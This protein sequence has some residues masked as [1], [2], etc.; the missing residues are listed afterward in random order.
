[1][2]RKQRRAA[3]K[4]SSP[5]GRVRAGAAAPSISQLFEDAARFQHQN[6]LDDAAAAYE[7]LLLLKPDHAEASNNLGVVLLAQRKLAEASAR[8]AR[9]LE[10][11]PQLFDQFTAICATLVSVLPPINEAM[12]RAVAAWPK[13]LPADQLL[14][15]SGLDAIA[16]DPLLLC[17][18]QSTSVREVALERLLTS[19]RV[20]LLNDAVTG[21]PDN[22]AVLVFCCALAKQCFINEYV[23][24]TT[25]PKTAQVD[26]LKASL[27]NALELNA[28]VPSL[29]L[30][31]IAMYRAVAW[32]VVRAGL[33]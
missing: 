2:N 25:P 4:Q 10:L 28:A 22:E 13:R 11:T 3:L 6:K 30:A 7:R 20:S 26:Q 15:S 24:D 9:A 23:F 32:P 29:S 5:A 31:A 8:F 27:A 19:L 14:G 21:A 1:M 16:A 12:R 17:V 18:L 33:A